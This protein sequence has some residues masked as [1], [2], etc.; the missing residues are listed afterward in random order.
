[1]KFAMDC[2]T[3]APTANGCWHDLRS[4]APSMKPGPTG[5]SSRRE[6]QT[7]TKPWQ[8]PR[9][10]SSESFSAA[11]LRI[12]G[13]VWILKS[14]A[15]GKSRQSRPLHF[16]MHE[17]PTPVVEHEHLHRQAVLRRGDKLLHEHG[18]STITAHGND[19]AVLIQRLNTIR[20]SQCHAHRGIVE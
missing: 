10:R 11:A 9:I 1:M 16:E 13:E 20:H 3:C 12:H 4:L 8:M 5:N 19:L 2:R 17:A 14:R 7:P 18:K 15:L 6:H